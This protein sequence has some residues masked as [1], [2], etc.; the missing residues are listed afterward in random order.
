MQQQYK[1]IYLSLADF[2]SSL[3]SSITVCMTEGGDGASVVVVVV[4]T[5]LGGGR[6][7]VDGDVVSRKSLISCY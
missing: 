2:N 6:V 1:I 3:V 4:I 7:G 5:D